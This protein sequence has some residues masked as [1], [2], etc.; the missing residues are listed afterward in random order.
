MKFGISIFLNVTLAY[1]AGLVLPW[2]GFVAI[3]FLVSAFL[4]QKNITSFLSGFI[5][6][7]LLWL[8]LAWVIDSQNNQILSQRVATLL[9]LNGNSMLLMIL[10]GAIGG[11]LGGM[12]A[13]SGSYLRSHKSTTENYYNNP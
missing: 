2:W 10:T 1:L 7:F 5:S 4:N 3:L 11:V 9:P 8:V 13:L 12:A 6:M